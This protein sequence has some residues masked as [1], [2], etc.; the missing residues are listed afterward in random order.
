MLSQI[1]DQS[2][3]LNTWQQA[4]MIAAFLGL[5]LSLNMM[6]KFVLGV[7]GFHFAVAVTICHLVSSHAVSNP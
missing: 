7:Y 3:P 2:R 1:L 6:G 5:N 4:V